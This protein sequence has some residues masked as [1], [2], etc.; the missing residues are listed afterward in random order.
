MGKGKLTS[1]GWE[2]PTRAKGTRGS[3]EEVN[4]ANKTLV[5]SNNSLREELD[6]AQDEIIALEARLAE[7]DAADKSAAILTVLQGLDHSVD[8]LWTTEGQVRVDIVC[9]ALEDDDIT[10]EMIEEVCP[11]F[12]RD[13]PAR[14]GDQGSGQE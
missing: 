8:S 13:N 9:D 6:K 14:S 7:Y 4:A 10:R 5:A 12:N 1:K 11:G 3:L 2:V